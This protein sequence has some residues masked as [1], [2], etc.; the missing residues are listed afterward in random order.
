MSLIFFPL[1]NHL[2][3][4]NFF[5]TILIVYLSLGL[6]STILY[7]KLLRCTKTPYYNIISGRYLYIRAISEYIVHT[8]L[9]RARGISSYTIR[10]CNNNI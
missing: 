7:V 10:L 4:S 8:C 5:H 6:D 9:W 3:R 2:L 1:P